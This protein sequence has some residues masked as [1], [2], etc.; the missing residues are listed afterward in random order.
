M[1]YAGFT[2]SLLWVMVIGLLGPSVPAIVHDLDISYAQAGFLFTLLSLGSLFGSSLG[3]IAS[4]YV[5]RKRIFASFCGLFAAGLACVGFAPGYIALCLTVFGFSLFGSPIG[6]IGQSVMLDMYPRQRSR[7]LSLQTL[8]A[9]VGSFLAPL[10]VSVNIAGGLSW[11]WPFVETAVAVGLLTGAVMAVRIPNASADRGSRAPLASV[12]RNPNMI[13]AAAL[14][15]LYVATDLGFSYWLAQYFSAEL[16]VPM[17]LASAVVSVFLVGMMAGRLT[18]SWLVKRIATRSILL[19]GLSIALVALL[20][21]LL[22]P[23]VTVKA[24]LACLYGLGIGPVFPLI[25]AKASEEYPLQSGAVTGLLFAC[26]SLG[27]M[28]FPFLLGVLASTFGIGRSYLL[29]L[30]VLLVVFLGILVW[31]RMRKARVEHVE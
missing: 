17:R 7:Y 29:C 14:V 8:F 20:G 21:F 16:G 22:I 31:I 6:S 28:V 3:A 9:A 19:A 30:S 1:P 26:V 12:L 11:R 24:G 4:D 5:N 2:S 10:L 25:V 15:F 18:T 13:I 27:G 23:A